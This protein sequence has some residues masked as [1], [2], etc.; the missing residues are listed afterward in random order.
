MHDRFTR[1]VS[2]LRMG[3]GMSPRLA[4]GSIYGERREEGHGSEF[5]FVWSSCSIRR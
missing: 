2:L 3:G 1:V 5:D 4:G